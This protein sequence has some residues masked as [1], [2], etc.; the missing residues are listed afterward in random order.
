MKALITTI[1]FGEK[2]KLPLEQL[3]LA[4]IET[5]L[6]PLG[7]KLQG[8]ELAD[9]ISGFDILIA[10]TETISRRVL[11]GADRLKLISRVGIGLDN[12]DLNFARSKGIKVAYT[13]DAPAPAVTELAIGLMLGLLRG[14]HKANQKMHRGE[15]QR[16]FGRRISEVTIGIIGVGRIG[17]RVIRRLSAFGSPRILAND[18]VPNYS[19]CDSLKIEWAAKDQILAEADLISFHLPLTLHTKNLVSE[20][21]I[22]TMKSDALLINTARGGIINEQ[23]LAAALAI[24]RIGGAAIDVFEDE[25]YR[26]PLATFDNCILTAHMGSMSE[27]CRSRMEIEAVDEALRFVKSEPLLN[28]VPEFEYD[29]QNSMGYES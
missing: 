2:N 19:V 6:N 15:W 16:I 7:R 24:D 17:G 9:L 18:L 1:P 4:G 5:T 12:V 13:P 28:P 21:E 3:K 26:G 27:D 29:V 14:I 20:A 25:P 8:E 11:E 22:E 10:G 23:A